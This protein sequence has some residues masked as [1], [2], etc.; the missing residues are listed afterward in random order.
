LGAALG[1]APQSNL[2]W[3]YDHRDA[4]EPPQ[5]SQVWIARIDPFATDR[6]PHAG[7][8]TVTGSP[9][10]DGYMVTMAV[11]E[12]ILQVVGQDFRQPDY[13]TP[14]G[15]PLI[16]V[17]RPDWL[18]SYLRVIWPERSDLIRWPLS[19]RI[20]GSDWRRLADWENTA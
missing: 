2:T 7:S 17:E 15:L 19:Y 11:G 10:I 14:G 6:T 1:G 9:D 5:G 20:K 8:H 13:L 12:L 4:P 16:T 3:L 18:L